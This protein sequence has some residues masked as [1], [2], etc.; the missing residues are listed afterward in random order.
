MDPRMAELG[1]VRIEPGEE[2]LR[3]HRQHEETARLEHAPD[4]AQEII[5]TRAVLEHVEQRD[6]TKVPVWIGQWT[7]GGD[8]TNLEPLVIALD[9]TQIAA[10][11]IDAVTIELGCLGEDAQE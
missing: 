2:M 6:R 9:L 8:E 5:L 3:R 7:N 4:L 1:I 10:V 11:R